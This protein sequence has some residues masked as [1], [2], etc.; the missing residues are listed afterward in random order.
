MSA[1]FKS[2]FKTVTGNE[3]S[4]CHYTTRLDTYGCGCEHDCAYC[5]AKSLLAFRGLWDV[6]DPKVAS[7]EAIKKK[8]KR[9]EPGSIL[10][11][12][13]MTD[14]LQPAERRQGVTKA[15]IDLLNDA[16]IGYLIVTKSHLIGTDEYLKRLN[17][18]LAHIQIT[19]T[20]TD[21]RAALIYERCSFS[22]KRLDAAAK[23]QDAGIDVAI[24][25]SPFISEFIDPSVIEKSGVKKIVVEFLRINHWIEKWIGDLIDMT[26]YTL[27]RGGYRHLPLEEKIC[28]LDALRVALPGCEFTVCED[29]PEHWVYWRDNVNV[30]PEDCCNLRR[31]QTC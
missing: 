16:C 2:F 10:R 28:R 6:K 27:K 13:G 29:V 26:P 1:E 8:I 22:S 18:K 25:L 12:G 31:S 19:V 17:P 15:T 9:I 24:R 3:G 11:L 23:L 4:L 21:D 5:Y 30:N 20:N 7:L 14:C